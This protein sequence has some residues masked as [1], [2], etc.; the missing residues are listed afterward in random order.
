MSDQSEI[1]DRSADDFGLIETLLWTEDGGF[2]Y[3]DEHVARLS[4]LGARARLSR[5]ATRRFS[6]R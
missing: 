4:R 2:L 1:P 5:I 6:R 3:L